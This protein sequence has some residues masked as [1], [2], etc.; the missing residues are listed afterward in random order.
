[1]SYINS[2][3]FFEPVTT[4]TRTGERKLYFSARSKSGGAKAELFPIKLD[5]LSSREYRALCRYFK[6]IGF[7]CSVH[8]KRRTKSPYSS[9][10]GRYKK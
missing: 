10:K 2:T 4:T 1:M 8:I 5:A 6:K 3:L 9:S 7:S